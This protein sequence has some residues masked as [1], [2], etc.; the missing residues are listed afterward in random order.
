MLSFLKTLLG[1]GDPGFAKISVV[2]ASSRAQRPDCLFVDVRTPGEWA[3]GVPKGATTISL[4]DPQLA[5]RVQAL[6]SEKQ[7]AAIVVICRSGMRSAQAAR[8]LV[9]AG[10]SD[11]HNVQGGMMAWQSAG[12]P[13]TAHKG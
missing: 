11:V 8:I 9:R 10:F 7:D 13:V 3:S 6:A 1:L 12:L 5:M 2:E 4:Q